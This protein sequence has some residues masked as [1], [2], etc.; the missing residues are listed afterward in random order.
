MANPNIDLA[1]SEESTDVTAIPKDKTIGGIGAKPGIHTGVVDIKCVIN[2]RCPFTKTQKVDDTFVFNSQ[3]IAD[4]N[5]NY[6]NMVSSV[7]G[8]EGIYL[9]PIYFKRHN[10]IAGKNRSNN[11]LDHLPINKTDVASASSK[12]YRREQRW[13]ISPGFFDT[14]YLLPTEYI[15]GSIAGAA[16]GAAAGATARSSSA[17]TGA[18]GVSSGIVAGVPP[19][20]AA[21]QAAEQAEIEQARADQAEAEAEQYEAEQYMAAVTEAA[22]AAAGI[23]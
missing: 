22:K 4:W 11:I 8:A 15:G 23:E 7:V 17:A 21:E 13:I 10:Y 18:V 20:Q 19:E 2:R 5:D 3:S 6:T 12:I 14:E 9:N 16:I 1:F